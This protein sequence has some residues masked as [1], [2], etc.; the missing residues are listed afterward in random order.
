MP[1]RQLTVSG[2]P[3]ISL[4][5]DEIEVVCVPS[6]GGKLT[7][8]RRHRGREWFWRN[9]AIPFAPPVWGASYIETA[10][11]GGWDE[12][13]PTIGPSAMPGALPGEPPL[14]DHGELWA[15]PW[16]HAV[17]E[18]PDG[19]TL[20]G[21]VEGRLLPYDLRREVTV[22]VDQPEVRIGYTLRHRGEVAFPFIW[23]AHP[24]L[25]VQK[26]S[27]IALPTVERAY[28]ISVA[29]R[30]DLA[31]GDAISWPLEGSGA[32]W[33]FPG[34][35]GWALMVGA[36]LGASGRMEVTDPLRGERL[37]VDAS[38]EVGQVGVWIN[39][40][41]WAPATLGGRAGPAPYVNLGLEPCIGAPDRLDLAVERWR[42]AQTLA[43]GEERRW[44]LTIRL[45][46]PAGD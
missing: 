18:R 5:N 6:L 19:V 1:H 7:N 2:L 46:G 25:N 17:I 38:P 41:G 26:G 28:V 20:I 13:F 35:R 22:A 9:P 4:S 33:T 16:T 43:P 12:C 37:Q 11:S 30:T 8:L 23:A 24:L 39:A 21:H 10:D 29:G 32:A 31:V 36:D 14:P 42:A 44:S 40:G 3:A 34:A 15:L 27:T 45:P